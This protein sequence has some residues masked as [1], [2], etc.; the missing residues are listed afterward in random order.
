MDRN[1]LITCFNDTFE[2]SNSEKLSDSTEK[3]KQSNRVYFENF[4][5]N[6]NRSKYN[7]DIIV[8]ANTTFAVA[9]K[10]CEFGKTAVLNFANPEVAGGGVANGAMAQEEC[11][12]RSSNLYACIDDRNVFND[13]YAYHRNNRNYFYSNRLIYTK[14]VTVFKSDDEI[15]QIMPENEW[16]NVDVITCAAP[17]LG[18][19]KYTNQTVLKEVFKSRIKNVLNRQ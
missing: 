3:A 11:L 5:S 19:Q 12:C 7:A 17:Y 16:F 18:K 14:D 9:K 15:P 10:Y 4:V 2:I 6:K 8:E 1:D 13:Y